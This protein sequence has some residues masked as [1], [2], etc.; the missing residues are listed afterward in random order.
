VV[1]LQWVQARCA[2]LEKPRIQEK[3]ISTMAAPTIGQFVIAGRSDQSI[4]VAIFAQPMREVEV[5]HDRIAA[6]VRAKP[7]L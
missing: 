2:D 1:C 5:L 3:E 7:Q 4:R 6:N